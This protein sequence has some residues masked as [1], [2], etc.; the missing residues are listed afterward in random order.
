VTHDPRIAL[1]SDY[2]IVIKQ[3]AMQEL[4][5]TGAEERRIA[6]EIKKLDDLLLHLRHQIREGGQLSGNIVGER[7]KA[8]GLSSAA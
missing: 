1:L 2:R 3:G 6:E 5:V 7:L 8:L 4:I